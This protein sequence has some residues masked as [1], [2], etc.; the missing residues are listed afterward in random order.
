MPA[1]KGERSIASQAIKHAIAICIPEVLPL[2]ANIT[3]IKP[4]QAH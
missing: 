2:A 3:A 1:T 4:S